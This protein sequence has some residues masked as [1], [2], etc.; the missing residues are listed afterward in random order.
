MQ[1]TAK[2]LEHLLDV[3]E[4]NHFKV[5][6]FKEYFCVVGYYTITFF[7]KLSRGSLQEYT[8]CPDFRSKT[9]GE[10]NE[11]LTKYNRL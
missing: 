3:P 8:Y 2:Q 10:V 11:C 1:L 6:P 5:I 4:K 7:K 9:L